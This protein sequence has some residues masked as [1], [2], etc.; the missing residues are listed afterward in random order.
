MSLACFQIIVTYV[1]KLYC[2]VSQKC[3]VDDL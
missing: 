3:Q 2:T 1:T